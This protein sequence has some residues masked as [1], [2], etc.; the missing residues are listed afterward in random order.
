[1]QRDERV[2]FQSVEED[3][4]HDEARGFETYGGGLD[5]EADEIEFEFAGGGDGDAGGDHED[6]EGEFAVW[7]GD[8]EGPGDEKDGDGV[9][10][11][12]GGMGG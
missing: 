9:E 6:D 8:A 12:Q 2:H 3:L 11:L 4:D 7:F 10:G 5:E 1:M